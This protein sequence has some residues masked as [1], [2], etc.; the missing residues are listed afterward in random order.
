MQKIVNTD[1]TPNEVVNLLFG[2]GELGQTPVSV[3]VAKRMRD[4]REIRPG[5]GAIPRG[6][7]HA[8]DCGPQGRAARR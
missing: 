2:Y 6:G 3:R 8:V 5:V 4:I 7:I 1:A